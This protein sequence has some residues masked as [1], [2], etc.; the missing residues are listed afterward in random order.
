MRNWWSPVED[1]YYEYAKPYET[2]GILRTNIEIIDPLDPHRCPHCKGNS[3][4]L[5]RELSDL[6]CINCG[7][8]DTEHF[9]PRM[10]A[11]IEW[12]RQRETLYGSPVLLSDRDRQRKE[13]KNRCNAY[14]SRYRKARKEHYKE[15][16]R[17]YY[18]KHRAEQIEYHRLYRLNHKNKGIEIKSND[19]IPLR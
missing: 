10:N 7:W 15:N 16:S 11:F 14:Y 19:S 9:N 13:Y 17:L 5:Q 6:Y 3:A 8:R 2:G 18:I 1:M 4:R 12:V